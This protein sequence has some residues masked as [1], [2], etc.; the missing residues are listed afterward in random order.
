MKPDALA[1]ETSRFDVTRMGMGIR[2]YMVEVTQI[3]ENLISLEK[4]S[5]ARQGPF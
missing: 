4:H 3:Q 5:L 1:K 2:A